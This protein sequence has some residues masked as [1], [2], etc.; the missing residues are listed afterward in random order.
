MNPALPRTSDE[1]GPLYYKYNFVPLLDSIDSNPNFPPSNLKIGP[2]TT[3]RKCPT[4]EFRQPIGTMDPD[5]MVHWIKFLAAIVELCQKLSAEAIVQFLGLDSWVAET[6]DDPKESTPGGK[7]KPR[8]TQ[9]S[10]ADQDA[11]SALSLLSTL[12]PVGSLS[13]LITA[14]E[15]AHVQLDDETVRFWRRKAWPEK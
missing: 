11:L 13:R 5:T 7:R 15:S 8:Y 14:M 4:I 12:Q 1:Y 10:Q 9:L 2:V 3:K 6:C